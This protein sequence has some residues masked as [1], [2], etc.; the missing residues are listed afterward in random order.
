MPQLDI[1]TY[2]PQLF[3]LAAS[4]LVLYLLMKAIALPQVDAALKA[5]RSR[6]DD[7]LTRAGELKTQAEAVL[8]AYEKSLAEARSQAQAVLKEGAERLAA[9]AAR[10]QGEL[11]QK[12]AAEAEAAEREIAAAKERAFRDME[13]VT[14]DLARMVAEKLTGAPP[15]SPSPPPAAPARAGA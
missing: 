1:S 15:P 7:D 10:R 9:E 8:G 5:R 12:L 14:R 3:W 2:L 13:T 6:I 4:F 11:A